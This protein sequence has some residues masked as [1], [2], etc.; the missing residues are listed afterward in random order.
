MWDHANELTPSQMEDLQV[1]P[2]VAKV[3]P[4]NNTDY[5]STV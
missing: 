1:K 3:D 2:F 5:T 4:E